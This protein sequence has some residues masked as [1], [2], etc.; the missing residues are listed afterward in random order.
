MSGPPPEKPG[1]GLHAVRA[2]LNQAAWGR[3]VVCGLFGDRSVEN[4]PFESV[5]TELWQITGRRIHQP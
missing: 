5:Q 3:Q 2:A 4:L 1:A